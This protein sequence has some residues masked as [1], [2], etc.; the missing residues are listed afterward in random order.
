MTIAFRILIM[1]VSGAGKTT[2]GQLLAERMGGDFID[3][4]DLHPSA[5]I[6]KMRSGIPLN[7]ADRWPWLDRIVKAVQGRMKVQPV[8]VG[9][10]ALKKSYRQRLAAISYHLVYLKGHPSEIKAR[11]QKRNGHFM[12]SELLSSQFTDLEEPEDALI[13]PATWTPEEIVKHVLK[14]LTA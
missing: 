8:I 5:N 2:V 4:D 6:I 11:L 14:Q 9:C 12:P 1:G 13:V 3:G 10:S 7:D